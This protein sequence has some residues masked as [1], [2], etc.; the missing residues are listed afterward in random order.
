M[1]Q[2]EVVEAYTIFNSECAEVLREFYLRVKAHPFMVGWFFVL[3]LTGEWMIIQI[4]ML[5]EFLSLRV[6]LEY[7]D[8]LI[9][10]LFVLTGISYTITVNGYVKERKLV[11]YFAQ[12][13]R[14]FEIFFGKF[15]KVFWLILGLIAIALS[16]MTS[17]ILFLHAP[18]TIPF[19]FGWKLIII[20]MLG[21]S[22]GWAVGFFTFLKPLRKKLLYLYLFSMFYVL[23]WYALELQFLL[24]CAGAYAILLFFLAYRVSM[25]A[26]NNGIVL[27]RHPKKGLIKI[28]VFLREWKMK[29][30]AMAEWLYIVRYKEHT[31]IFLVVVFAIIGQVLALHLVPQ[32]ALT[33][34]MGKYTYAAVG[35]TAMY[36]ACALLCVISALSVVGK[37]GDAFWV[38]K[39]MPLS[40]E[41]I[42]VA[43]T[44]WILLTSCIAIPVVLLT[45]PLYLFRKIPLILFVIFGGITAAFVSTAVG[46]WGA[47]RYPYFSAWHRDSTDIITTYNVLI[48]ALALNAVFLGIPLQ[49][50]FHDKVLGI[51][52]AIFSA[53]MGALLYVLA[54]KYGGT[55]FEKIQR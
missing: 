41:K 55:E 54:C 40:G 2:G 49:I 14:Y 37:D 50:Y 43:K 45:L 38:L 21:S 33:G 26:W 39:T 47:A 15:L 7:K 3:L 22:G 30:L 8:I 9:F 27:E 44:Y 1:L 51:L 36:V 32:S 11:W 10:A 53:D 52:A 31:S 48:L 17:L 12:P 6:F 24:V 29:K 34:P 42:M 35:G 23:I 4:I 16:T 20:G 13:V 25:E 19:E 5:S 28:P 18:L 46:T